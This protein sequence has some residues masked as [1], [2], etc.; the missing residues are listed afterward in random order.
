MSDSGAVCIDSQTMSFFGWFPAFFFIDCEIV[1]KIRKFL[2]MACIFFQKCYYSRK[3]FEFLE[4][5]KL[6][7]G[8]EWRKSH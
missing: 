1:K 7:K 5:C 2:C 6:M 8:E 4:N 3:L